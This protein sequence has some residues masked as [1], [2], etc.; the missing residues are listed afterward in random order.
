MPQARR[1]IIGIPC[2]EVKQAEPPTPGWVYNLTLRSTY[3]DAIWQAGGLPLSLPP[4]L[5]TDS[6]NHYVAACDGFV[7]PGGPDLDPALYG[8]ALHE[9]T[10]LVDKRRE[11]FDLALIRAVVSADKPWL[12]ICMGCQAVNVALGGTLIQDILDLVPGAEN[13]TSQRDGGADHPP[14]HWAQIT[15]GSLLHRLVGSRN[16]LVNTSHHQAVDKVAPDL[17]VTARS[18]DGIIEALEC[19]ASKFGLALQWHPEWL[20]AESQHLAIFQAFVRA[21]QTD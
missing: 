2:S 10:R 4:L 12:G 16:L 21:A 18:D 9:K 5:N 7:F 19:P 3:A 14:R 13:H 17:I 1:P 8:Q 15:Q 11:N 20:T 6:V